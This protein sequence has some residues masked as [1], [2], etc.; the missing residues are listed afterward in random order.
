MDAYTDTIS[1]YIS[2]TLFYQNLDK[3]ETAISAIL[4]NYYLIL[5]LSCLTHLRDKPSSQHSL[6]RSTSNSKSWLHN[7]NDS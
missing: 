1:G 5:H 2:G 6:F 4:N 7:Y 3:L